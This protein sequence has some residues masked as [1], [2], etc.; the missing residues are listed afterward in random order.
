MHVLY[1]RIRPA[2]DTVDCKL[3][4]RHVTSLSVSRLLQLLCIMAGH[5]RCCRQAA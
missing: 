2:T 3:Q 5:R 4:C 1:A